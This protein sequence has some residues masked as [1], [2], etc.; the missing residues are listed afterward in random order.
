M[1]APKAIQAERALL[2][3]LLLD[4][5]QVSEVAATLTPADFFNAGH[6]HV[7]AWLVETERKGGHPDPVMLADHMD[8]TKSVERFGGIA[9]VTGLPEHCPSTSNLANY[10]KQVKEASTR[11]RLRQ[12]GGEL[13]E[14][15]LS[16]RPTP[17]LMREAEAAI[18]ALAAG[19][20]R[21]D[22]Q[23]IGDVLATEVV[24]LQDACDDPDG[25]VGLMT[26]YAALDARL[27]GMRGGE[28]VVLAARPAMGK[29]SCA[30][31]VMA[32]VAEGGVGVGFFSLEMGAGE[33]AKRTLGAIA[34]VN[35]K[36]IR[37][38]TI[39]HADWEKIEDAH[40]V[41]HDAPIWIEDTP[42]L[43]IGQIRSKARRLKAMHP[44]VGLIVVDYIQ[45][46]EG[47]PSSKGNREQAVSACSRGLKHLAKELEV[48]VIA[49]AQL[50]RGVEQRQDKR[51]MMSDLRESGAIEQ[52]ADVVWFIYRDEYYNPDT[53]TEPGVAEM[54]FAKT[55][56]GPTGTE[57]MS[58]EGR[59]CQFSDIGG[60]L[61]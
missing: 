53:T 33:L 50:N 7:F 54:I 17:E 51:P 59:Y 56:P 61:R 9:Y 13:A 27:L 15:C 44:E 10:A 31:N 20:D 32:K 18:Y 12:V 3:G 57:K 2:G 36:H 40:N 16:E 26:G 1:S 6:G 43:T 30:L 23:S 11:R 24:E 47:D 37:T 48:P 60:G 19:Q 28:L 22:W 41:L 29:T 14:A 35:G 21:R 58:W 55:R 52:D 38:A 34:Q 49:L 42:G 46:M 5:L 8:R 45:L 39:S 25:N 4:P